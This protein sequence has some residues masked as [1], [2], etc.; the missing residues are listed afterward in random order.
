MLVPPSAVAHPP[1]CSWQGGHTGCVFQTVS[2]S[3]GRFPIAHWRIQA[4]PC[5]CVRVCVLGTA[6]L[7]SGVIAVLL[8][9][10]MKGNVGG[11]MLC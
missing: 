10:W 4:V 11:A 3:G 8:G 7:A 2:G 5:V 1:S 6:H 9:L